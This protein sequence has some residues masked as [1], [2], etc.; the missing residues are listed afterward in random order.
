M[1][2]LPEKYLNVDV[3]NISMNKLLPSSYFSCHVEK[4]ATTEEQRE[5]FACF[6]IISLGCNVDYVHEK[7]TTQI[8]AE[9]LLM[10]PHVPYLGETHIWWFCWISLLRISIFQAFHTNPS[11]PSQQLIKSFTHFRLLFCPLI[12]S[13]EFFIYFSFPQLPTPPFHRVLLLTLVVAF[14]DF[15]FSQSRNE[16]GI[17]N[18]FF[19]S[20]SMKFRVSVVG[21]QES[22]VESETGKIFS[23]IRYHNRSP[24]VMSHSQL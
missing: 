6:F 16:R 14:C 5:T 23:L 12:S 13:W 24:F 11:V 15:S 21:G 4:V 8:N 22:I 9:T 10:P 1:S 19:F 3:K 7:F 2:K 18:S 17:K 20:F